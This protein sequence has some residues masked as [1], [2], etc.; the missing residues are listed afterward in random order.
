LVSIV[1]RVIIS[2]TS[3]SAVVVQFRAQA[4]GSVKFRLEWAANNPAIVDL[5]LDLISDAGLAPTVK[6][7]TVPAS[8]N[9]VVNAVYQIVEDI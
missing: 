7:G 9:V 8:G 1:R 2:G 4:G 5:A 3:T 6:L